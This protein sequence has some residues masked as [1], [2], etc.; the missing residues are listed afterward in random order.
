ME[1]QI[2]D[3]ARCLARGLASDAVREKPRELEFDRRTLAG[4]R[5]PAGATVKRLIPETHVLAAA[6]AANENLAEHLRGESLQAVKMRESFRSMVAAGRSGPADGR[7]TLEGHGSLR[8]LLPL[9]GH[10]AT[11]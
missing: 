3:L 10:T 8:G 11:F 5:A 4:L 1:R 6:A 9:A 2:A 7:M